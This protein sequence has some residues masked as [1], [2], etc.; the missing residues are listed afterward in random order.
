M[1]LNVYRTGNY[2]QG[3]YLDEEIIDTEEYEEFD[4]M[5]YSKIVALE[6]FGY[7]LIDKGNN[8]FSKTRKFMYYFDEENS[9][10]Y[11]YVQ[12]NFDE[13]FNKPNCYHQIA[14]GIHLAS[15]RKENNSIDLIYSIVK[16]QKLKNQIVKIFRERYEVKQC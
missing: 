2:Y 10:D 1:N 6:N 5:F 15:E 7:K 4:R 3:T 9:G 12:E 13:N 8:P 16:Y 11:V 14:I